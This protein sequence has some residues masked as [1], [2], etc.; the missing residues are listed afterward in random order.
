[1]ESDREEGNQTIDNKGTKYSNLAYLAMGVFG[2]KSAS[3]IFD[4]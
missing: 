3:A 1:M 2:T 4:G